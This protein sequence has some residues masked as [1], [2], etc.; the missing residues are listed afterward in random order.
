MVLRVTRFYHVVSCF[1]PTIILS[2]IFNVKI[3][4]LH[5][6]F[7]GVWLDWLGRVFCRIP[8][9]CGPP[10]SMLVHRDDD[11]HD[12]TKCIQN[13][14]SM[15]RNC[16]WCFWCLISVCIESNLYETTMLHQQKIV[17]MNRLPLYTGF[18]LFWDVW[19]WHGLPYLPVR[20]H[21]HK[22]IRLTSDNV[23]TLAKLI[24]NSLLYEWWLGL[25][26]K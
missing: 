26:K 18:V 9:R 7:R 6:D 1:V 4:E 12:K 25:D 3:A 13:W 22:A 24:M 15:E 2:Q 19:Y 17:L 8:A 11:D 5:G 16:F 14:W 10:V 23:H 21:I 20:R